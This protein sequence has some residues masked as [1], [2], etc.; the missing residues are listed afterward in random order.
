MDSLKYYNY[1]Y[2]PGVFRFSNPHF[3]V[4]RMN[5]RDIKRYVPLRD[6]SLMAEEAII[7]LDPILK[8][9]SIQTKFLLEKKS[10]L[11]NGHFPN[12]PVLKGVLT[13]ELLN[14]AA[15]ILGATLFPE[16][17]VLLSTFKRVSGFECCGP[18]LI[19]G[20]TLVT[21]VAFLRLEK[22]RKFLLFSFLGVAKR[23]GKVVARVESL[24]GTVIAAEKEVSLEQNSGNRTTNH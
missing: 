6:D 18:P 23:D 22:M 16:I 14:V 17:K 9:G 20:D 5:G 19:P 10:S 12:A 3:I 15:M 11:F 24:T 1:P 7:S 13:L 2:M 4:L 8:K 21:E